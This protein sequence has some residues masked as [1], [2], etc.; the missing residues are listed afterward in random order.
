M[1]A[2]LL[3]ADGKEFKGKIKGKEKWPFNQDTLRT[4]ISSVV[5]I[6]SERAMESTDKSE[7]GLDKPSKKVVLKTK[8]DGKE[9]TYKLLFGNTAPNEAGYYFMVDGEDK[10]FTCYINIVY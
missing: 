6:S 7:Y 9:K 1:K 3:L 4:M 2:T 5:S 10:I 8:E